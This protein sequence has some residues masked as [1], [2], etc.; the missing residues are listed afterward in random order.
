MFYKKKGKPEEGEIL[1]CTVKKI[2]PYSVFVNIDEYESSEGMIHISEIAPG[3]IRNLRDY[4]IEGKRIVCKVI[5]INRQDNIDLSLR[6]VPTN[7]MVNK[8]N[9]YKQEE[10]A[11]K[12]L[13]QIGKDLNYD[14]K[15]IYE[16]VGYK[17]IEK[18]G[19]LYGLF[20]AIVEKGKQV[21]DDFKA[22]EK[23]S[24]K[25]YKTVIEKIK[26]PEVTLSYELNIKTYREDG[27]DVIKQILSEAEKM[28]SKIVYLGAPRYKMYIK[29]TDYKKAENILSK[30]LQKINEASKKLGYSFSYKKDG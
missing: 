12:L 29:S 1:I 21:V 20:S 2:T 3:R 26:P 18:Y 30:I 5:N 4:V 27:I 23:L 28:G 22:N 13:E 6:R 7:V 19:S 10:K 15:K 14:L 9:S 25:L 11:E 24:E 16:Q 8:I 17:A